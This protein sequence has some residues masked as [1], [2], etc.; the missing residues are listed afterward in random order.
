MFLIIVSAR[1]EPLWCPFRTDR[2]RTFSLER[3]KRRGP[4][5]K[6]GTEGSL[7]PAMVGIF[8]FINIMMKVLFPSLYLD[9]ACKNLFFP[10]EER[11]K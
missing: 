11:Y 5:G 1:E 2:T 4:W 7:F 3:W 6:K 9:L 8:S 10:P